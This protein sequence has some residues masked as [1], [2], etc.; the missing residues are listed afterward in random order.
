MDND[1]ILNDLFEE[2]LEQGYTPAD[3]EAEAYNRFYEQGEWAY[4]TRTPN[5]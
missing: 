4:E 2:L 1:K 5:K 3:A